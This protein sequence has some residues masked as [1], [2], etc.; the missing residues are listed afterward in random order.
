MRKQGR[1]IKHYSRSVP[2]ILHREGEML[3]V[4]VKAEIAA[5]TATKFGVMQKQHFDKLVELNNIA[6]VACQIKPGSTTHFQ[7]QL[8]AI[9]QSVFQRYT[10]TGRLGVNADERKQIPILIAL[11]EAYWKGQT[12]TFYNHCGAEVNAFYKEKFALKPLAE[13]QAA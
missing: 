1:K 12:T 10:N 9:L 5:F 4:E 11:N 7:P 8:E 2:M 13:L 3:G 6:K